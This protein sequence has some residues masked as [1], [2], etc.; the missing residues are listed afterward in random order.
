VKIGSER[1]LVNADHLVKVFKE[2]SIS[3]SQE[4]IISLPVSD[5]KNSLSTT[6]NDSLV[7]NTA[8]SVNSEQNSIVFDQAVDNANNGNDQILVKKKPSI[9]PMVLRR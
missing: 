7:D 9:S 8:I 1:K 5:S 3:D 4:L 6:V 2:A